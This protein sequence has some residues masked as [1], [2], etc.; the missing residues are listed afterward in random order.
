MGNIMSS[1]WNSRGCSKVSP[2]DQKFT[3][4]LNLVTNDDEFPTYLTPGLRSLLA[5]QTFPDISAYEARYLSSIKHVSL[6]NRAGENSSPL[7]PGFIHVKCRDIC[8]N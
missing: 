6:Q 7:P 3:E 8:R 2:M 1:Q 4:F 5:M